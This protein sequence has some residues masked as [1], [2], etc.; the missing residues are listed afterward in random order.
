MS[1]TF[2]PIADIIDDLQNGRMVILTDNE[3][4]E[5]EGDLVLPAQMATPDAI[6]F[7]LTLARGYMCLSL[8]EADCDRL[9]LRPQAA[10]NTSLRA[11]P[12]TVSIDGAPRHGV[13]TG[14][15]T[16]DRARTVQLAI[17]PSSTPDDFVRP[18]HINPLRS[19]DGGVLVRV[20]QT[21]GSL[22]LCRLAGL[23]PSALIIEIV[24]PDG[25][26]ARLPDLERISVE[27][28]IKMCSVAQVIEHR[29]A[30]QT[31]VHRHEP[32]RGVE[33]ETEFGPF[34]LIT[35]DSAVD[36]LPHLALTLGGVGELGADGEPI[37]RDEPTLVRMHRRHLLGDLFGDLSSGHG[38]ASTGAALRESMR[39]IQAQGAGA[40]VY[41]R[42]EGTGDDPE[43]RLQTINRQRLGIARRTQAGSIAP[44]DVPMREREFGIGSQILRQLGLTKLRLM[45]NAPVDRPGLD[46]FGLEIVEHVPLTGAGV[47]RGVV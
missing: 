15:S 44:Q 12:F 30:R 4:R 32:A 1:S 7:M 21:E 11:T 5:N 8:T 14:V 9:D 41:L 24:R 46:A 34:N 37:R 2:A 28:G 40:I 17:D 42:P 47:A 26:M 6:N 25:E 36:P 33:I 39:M 22:D 18:G 29:L 13:G 23:H 27:H 45:T 16:F 19:R 10:D 31:L 38:G 35:F 20:G 43:S 3:D